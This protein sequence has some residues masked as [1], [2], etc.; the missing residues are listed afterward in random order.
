MAAPEEEE[1]EWEA[2][3]D[4]GGHEQET[5]PFAGSQEPGHGAVGS[6]KYYVRPMTGS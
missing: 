3:W 5:P 4:T 6:C 2:E 1:A